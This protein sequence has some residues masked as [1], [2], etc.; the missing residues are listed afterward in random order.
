MN[1]TTMHTRLDKLDVRLPAQATRVDR[2]LDLSRISKTEQNH[3]ERM[4]D[5]ITV[6]DGKG[7]IQKNLNV[8]SVVELKAL[9]SIVR[10]VIIYTTHS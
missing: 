7:N 10:K 8:L 4:I 6:S 9:S 5:Q 1:L 3:L 2:N